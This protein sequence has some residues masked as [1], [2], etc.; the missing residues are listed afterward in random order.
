MLIEIHHQVLHENR[1]IVVARFGVSNYIQ[2]VNYQTNAKH[3]RNYFKL[4]SGHITGEVIWLIF[5][6][7]WMNIA[8]KS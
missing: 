2:M 1:S 7:F 3:Q 8:H 5:G 4:R 6:A